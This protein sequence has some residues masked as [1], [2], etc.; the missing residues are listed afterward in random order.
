MGCPLHCLL[1]QG[2]AGWH[3]RGGASAVSEGPR[4]WGARVFG[5]ICLCPTC[6]GPCSQVWQNRP[7][8]AGPVAFFKLQSFGLL[9][10][11]FLCPALAR[12]EGFKEALWVRTGF[13]LPVPHPQQFLAVWRALRCPAAASALPSTHLL[14]LQASPTPRPGLLSERPSCRQPLPV[15]HS[16]RSPHA[17]PVARLPPAME[18]WCHFFIYFPGPFLVPTVSGWFVWKWM[19]RWILGER[20]LLGSTPVKRKGKER[21]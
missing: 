6:Q 13:Q 2:S 21:V 19:L 15:L 7:T 11:R 20:C 17:A 1:A 10:P 18:P 12:G 3:L 4:S 14:C 9:G 5:S 8:W 16:E